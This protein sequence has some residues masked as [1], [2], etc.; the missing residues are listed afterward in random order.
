[1]SAA[2]AAEMGF[3]SA[4]MVSGFQPSNAVLWQKVHVKVSYNADNLS[5]VNDTPSPPHT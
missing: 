5:P 3:N 4:D 1:M 2:E